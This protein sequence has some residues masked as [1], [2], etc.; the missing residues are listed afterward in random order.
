[1]FVILKIVLKAAFDMSSRYR[2]RTVKARL[3]P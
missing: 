1:M 2:N 3:E